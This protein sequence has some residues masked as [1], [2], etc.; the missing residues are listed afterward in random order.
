[1]SVRKQTANRRTLYRTCGTCGKSVVTTAD[2]PWIR[3]IPRDGKK[4]AITYFC[5]E[6]CFAAS[7]KHIGWY[8]G[9]AEQRRMERE[10]KRDNKERCRRYNAAHRDKRREAAR[11]YREQNPEQVAADNAYYKRKRKLLAEGR[12]YEQV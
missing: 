3:Q 6:K 12:T 11:S 7:Y 2:T 1:M 9:K 8:D 5:C 10:S 4:L